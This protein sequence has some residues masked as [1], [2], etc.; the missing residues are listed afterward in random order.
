MEET[1]YKHITAE[2][3]SELDFNKVTLIDLREPDEV[4]VSGIDN[5]INIPF[6]GGFD[7]FLPSGDLIF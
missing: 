3:F 1:T 4:L 6:S 2:E 5:A 7:N